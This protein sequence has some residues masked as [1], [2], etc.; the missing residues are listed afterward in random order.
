MAA[1]PSMRNRAPAIGPLGRVRSAAALALGRVALV[2]GE[3]DSFTFDESIFSV[4]N[5]GLSF[6][7]S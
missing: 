1:S 2:S 4:F 6:I 5:L 7:V 3:Q